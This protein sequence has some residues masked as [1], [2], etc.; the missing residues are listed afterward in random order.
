MRDGAILLL[1]VEDVLVDGERLEGRP[2]KPDVEKKDK[3]EFADGADPV[4]EAALNLAS[5]A[6]QPRRQ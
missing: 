3:V 1:P 4:L 5:K 2:V 6:P